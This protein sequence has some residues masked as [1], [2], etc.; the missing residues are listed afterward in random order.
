MK[1][2]D[3]LI[4]TS[5]YEGSPNVLVEALFLKVRYR[6]NCPTG[7][8]EILN[9]GKFGELV[10]IGDYSQISRSSKF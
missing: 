3:I 4:L 8:K 7:P 1:Q 5:L 2:A 10:E 6:Y 9:N